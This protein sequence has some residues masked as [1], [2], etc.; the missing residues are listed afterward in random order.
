MVRVPAQLTPRRKATM[1]Q[2]KKFVPVLLVR[3]MDESIEFYVNRLGFRILWRSA[4]DGGGENSMLE[5]GS[6]NL[7][8]S[9]EAHLGEE[10]RFS[11]TLYVDMQGVDALYESLKDRVP[12]VWPLEVMPYG[13]KEFGIRDCNGYT[14]AFAESV[15]A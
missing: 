2:L 4:G 7:M 5:A 11:G 15:E 13:Q 6:M 1:Y 8:L 10:P 12:I 14:L 3:N 9:T